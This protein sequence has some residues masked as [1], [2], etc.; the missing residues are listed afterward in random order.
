MYCMNS[1]ECKYGSSKTYVCMRQ[2]SL[3]S[4]CVSYIH[5]YIPRVWAVI[6]QWAPTS[7]GSQCEWGWHAVLRLRYSYDVQS[8]SGID[9]PYHL[10][11]YVVVNRCISPVDSLEATAT[12]AWMLC[13]VRIRTTCAFSHHSLRNPT[14]SIWKVHIYTCIHT[15]IYI[16]SS[17]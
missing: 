17:N 13:S 5:T 6:V 1:V 11:M 2:Y 8:D 14:Q 4:Y 9:Y 7:L 10:C 12:S 15:W 16:L 3:L